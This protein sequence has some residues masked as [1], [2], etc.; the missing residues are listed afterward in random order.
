MSCAESRIVRDQTTPSTSAW[1]ASTDVRDFDR[2][3]RNNTSA[4]AVNCCGRCPNSVFCSPVDGGCYTPDH[5]PDANICSSEYKDFKL[6]N[7]PYI[8]ERRQCCSFNNNNGCNNKFCSPYSGQ[9]HDE[10]R[11]DYYVSCEE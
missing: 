5:C 3:S 2:S 7:S 8:L 4:D 11:K 1:S 6:C 9:C 10:F